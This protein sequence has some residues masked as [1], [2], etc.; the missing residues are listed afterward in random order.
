M[1][2]H[3]A[4]FATLLLPAALLG[5]RGNA[6]RRGSPILL[7]ITF[8][9]FTA[10]STFRAVSVGNDTVEYHRVF[11]AIAATDS[12]QEALS[13]S[14][15]EYGYVL[16]NYL[17]SRLTQDFNI[18]LLIT[19]VFVYGS[20]VLFIK[21]YAA[22][23]S[24][25]VLFA[26]GMS[27]FYDLMLAVRQGIAVAIFLLAV[28]ALME[29]KLVRY[30]LLVVLASQ[31]HVS[32]LLLLVVYLIPYMRLSTFGDWFKWGALIGIVMF[33]LSWLLTWLLISSAY[34]GHYLHSDYADGGVR[35]ATVLLIITRIILMLLAATCGWNASV[36][37]DP[38]GRTRILLALAV[39]DVAMVVIAL[40]FNLLDRLEMYLTLPFA[41]GLANLAAHGE[42]PESSYVSALLVVIAFAATTTFF[43]YRPEW[44]HLFPYRTFLEEGLP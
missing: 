4:L 15:F 33:S 6:G 28:P 29:R 39:A 32:V 40:G 36:E 9:A 24:L 23:Y 43:L 1:W 7:G 41:V 10:F 26:F 37:A 11:K 27:V 19:S 18:L 13:V 42:R 5:L 8:V 34:Y 16:V 44:Y 22:S 25:A 38:S 21:R 35:S 14:R 3:F 17:V 30:V 2:I 31:F 12:F 20:A